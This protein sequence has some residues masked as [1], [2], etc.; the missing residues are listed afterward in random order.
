MIAK[1]MKLKQAYDDGDAIVDLIHK[2]APY[3][4]LAAVHRHPNEGNTGGWFRN[5][6]ALGGKVVFDG[7]D[8]H[9][10][11]QR[12]ITTAKKIF[13]AEVIRPVAMMTN[14][15][16]PMAALPQHLD[17][18]FFRGLT[19]REVPSW[20]LE[21]M[22]YSGLFHE[23]AIPVASAITWFYEGDGGEFEYWPDGPSAPSQ[24]VC[25]PYSNMCVI[26]D[27]E[28]TYHRVG[29]TGTPAEYWSE[30]SVPYD[31]RLAL[32]DD[33]HWALISASGETLATLPYEKVRLSVL[34]KAYCFET[35]AMAASYDD[36]S[37]DL[38][39]NLVADIFIENLSK[40]GVRFTEPS[41]PT[42]DMAWKQTLLEVYTPASVM[43]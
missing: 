28:Y 26:A 15:N 4:T 2:G 18:P 37:N 5:F 36:H 21:P 16:L 29:S 41:N 43:I 27:N 22:G 19:N 6:W 8:E 30:T 12:F 3:K 38:T 32:T 9:F 33:K 1:P 23:W 25:P 7:A 14:L 40:K 13:Q 11:N 35:E 39:A 10:N 24:S 17:L 20:M 42:T 34:W 31:A